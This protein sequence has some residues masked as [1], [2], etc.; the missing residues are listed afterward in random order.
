MMNIYTIWIGS[1]SYDLYIPCFRC[2]TVWYYSLDIAYHLDFD[3][4]YD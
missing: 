3:T 1:L 4:E 2:R